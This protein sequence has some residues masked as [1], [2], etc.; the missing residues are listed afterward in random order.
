MVSFLGTVEEEE[1]K[2]NGPTVPP[3]PP[4]LVLLEPFLNPPISSPPQAAELG[5]PKAPLHR[6]KGPLNGRDIVSD[7][8]LSWLSAIRRESRRRPVFSRHLG[9][10]PRTLSWLSAIRWESRRRLVFSRHLGFAPRLS[11]PSRVLQQS[12]LT[13]SWER[14]KTDKAYAFGDIVLSK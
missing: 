12:L 7:Q 1:I 8:T 9:F 10:A 11:P 14:L 2:A 5:E 6:E 13:S 4:Y 3:C